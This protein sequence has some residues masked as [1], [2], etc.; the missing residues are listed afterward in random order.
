M[1]RLV[2]GEGNRSYSWNNAVL[3][4]KCA[5]ANSF[6]EQFII[7]TFNLVNSSF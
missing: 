4:H 7:N 3:N 1:S 6:K 5:F 2:A